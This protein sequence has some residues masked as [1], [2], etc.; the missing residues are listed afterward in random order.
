MTTQ[1]HAELTLP[2]AGA[3]AEDALPLPDR[4]LENP[5]ELSDEIPEAIARGAS[6]GRP[7][8]MHP[9]LIQNRYT[10]ERRPMTLPAVALD[11]EHVQIGRASCRERVEN[12]E[13]AEAR[14]RMRAIA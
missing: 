6:F 7:A 11:N 4:L 12:A 8:S 3:G 10:R 1:Y 13:V 2:A 5:F 9:Y 14:E